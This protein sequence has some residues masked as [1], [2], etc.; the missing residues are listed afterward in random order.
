M[1][2]IKEKYINMLKEH[3]LFS[4]TLEISEMLKEIK[5]LD[6]E[7]RE[8]LSKGEKRF[9]TPISVNEV[10]A[11]KFPMR[12]QGYRGVLAWNAAYPDKEI[13]LP[14][15]LDI[16][17]VNL[18]TPENMNK[19]KEINPDI[20]ANIIKNIYENSNEEIRKKGVNM[21]GV[22]RNEPCIPEWAVPFIDVDKITN[23]I[24]SKFFPV[25]KSLS[26]KIFGSSK[27]TYHSNIV[28]L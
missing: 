16:I 2:D 24:L 4:D 1:A 25:F 18:D 17:K 26:L 9:M 19:L 12:M 23:D 3:V 7:I 5:A 20:H 21:L 11:Y 22:P 15:K 27:R 10:Q 8:S 13:V 6:I 14:E 28:N